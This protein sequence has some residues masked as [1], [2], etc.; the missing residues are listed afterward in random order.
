MNEMMERELGWD[1]EIEKDAGEYI[2]LPEGEYDFRVQSFERGRFNGS[3]KMPPCNKAILKI[4]INSNL[5]TTLI[6]HNLFLHT[7]TEGLLSAFFTSIG[8]KQKGEK[9]RMNWNLVP[10]STGRCKVIV[11]EWTDNSGNKKQSNQIDRFLPK[12]ARPAFQAGTF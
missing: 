9:L 5:G 7:K 6:T 4:E 10:G 12:Q 3:E 2:L 8:L 11:H 1:D